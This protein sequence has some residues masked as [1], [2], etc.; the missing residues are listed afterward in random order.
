MKS[1]HIKCLVTKLKNVFKFNVKIKKENER[2][3]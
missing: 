3:V 1:F 2:V